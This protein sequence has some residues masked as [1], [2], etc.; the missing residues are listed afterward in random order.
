MHRIVWIPAS[1]NKQ[2]MRKKKNANPGKRSHS[3]EVVTGV[4][5]ISRQGMGFVRVVGYETDII[6]RRENLKN[7]MDGDT[8]EVSL[9][10]KSSSAKRPEGIIVSVLKRKLS[11]L[12]GTVDLGPKTAFVI[13]DNSAFHRDI[14]IHPAHQKKIKQGDRVI[15]R[16]IKW[17]D[18]GRNPE[19]EIV[20]VLDAH[21]ESDIAM[22]DILLQNGFHLEFPDE[23]IRESE[24]LPDQITEVDAQNRKDL[25]GITTFTIDPHD[26][27]DF[28]DAI[29]FRILESGNLEV[30][31][32]IADVSHFIRPG[33][34]MDQE[35]Y[36]RATSVYLPDRVLPM[37]PEKI[38]NGLCSLRPM[39]DKLTFSTI[40]EMDLKGKI[41]S[42]WIGR[43][44]IHSKR[45]FTYEE[46]QE[47][48][49]GKD[50][51]DASILLSLHQI[52]QHYRQEKFTAGAINFSSEEARFVLDEHGV[53]LDVVVKESKE[54]H[55]LIEEFML[56]AN[57]TVAA[58]VGRM[59]W[60]NQPIPFPYRIHDRPDPEKLLT[61]SAFAAQFG[62]RF[63]LSSPSSIAQSF[64]R[65]V[66]GTQDKP[67]QEILHTLGIRT[68]AKA[69][70]STEN[71][72]HYGLGFKDYCHFTSPI[73]R[74]PDVMVH[75][76]LQDCL[77]EEIKPD[78]QMEQHCVH[79]SER[80]RKAM[81][82]EREAHKYKQV[83]WMLQHI[84]DEFEAT[85]SGVAPFGFWAIT[86][87]HYCEGLI[88][89]HQ[90]PQA[91]DWVYVEDEYALQNKRSKL[92]FRIGQ[93]I[94]IR[95]AAANLSK[96]QIDM[97]WTGNL[98]NS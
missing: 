61:F 69:V 95:I 54:S 65:M 11:E 80:E 64:N 3:Q 16:I 71:I 9:I 5:D 90:L 85:I 27:K 82:S 42:T 67:G 14:F 96:R 48:I 66:E 33:S 44:L 62:Y 70:Y 55:Q 52:A 30:G 28:D 13:P 94:R 49:E 72:G 18:A 22:K 92:R 2:T 7:A 12:I 74:Y 1:K 75:R 37:L 46:A 36:Q 25:R 21:S 26:A 98:S 15:V 32:H 39:E 97:E 50:D 31:V 56:L 45:R 17:G 20:S 68:M 35:A 58:Y 4:L 76:I 63:D 73:R 8:V 81:D 84:G 79:C 47:I 91:S 57:R 77:D 89:I 6:I 53:P 23:V 88:N 43:T 38:S 93:Q 59:K 24:A 86:N 60:K 78:E 10:R 29:S 40:F 41:F 87:A 34:A 83:E 51:P 19:G